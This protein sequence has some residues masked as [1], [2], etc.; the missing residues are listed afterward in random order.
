[1]LA[2]LPLGPYGSSDPMVLQV[3]VLR[4]T[5][6]LC[7]SGKL[8]KRTTQT[9]CTGMAT[10]TEATYEPKHHG[11]SLTKSDLTIDATKCPNY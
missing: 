9:I 1:M 3:S 8:N 7:S 6:Q 4:K 5:R 10:G 2:I 11:L